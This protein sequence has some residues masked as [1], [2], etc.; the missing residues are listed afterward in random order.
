M[1]AQHGSF[2][3]IAEPL[4]QWGREMIALSLQIACFNQNRKASL[5]FPE[6]GLAAA[7]SGSRIF[8]LEL[9]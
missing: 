4:G 8:C 1:R 7:A 6:F 2:G 5:L 9:L 3:L